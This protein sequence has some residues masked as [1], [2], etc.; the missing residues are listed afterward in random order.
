MSN[1]PPIGAVLRAK[2]DRQGAVFKEEF[3][4][5]AVE[6]IAGDIGLVESYASWTALESK[7]ALVR[8]LRLGKVTGLTRGWRDLWEV[9]S[10]PR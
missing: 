10:C 5:E 4:L 2:H 9:V 7:L 3:G 8:L 6:I 1:L